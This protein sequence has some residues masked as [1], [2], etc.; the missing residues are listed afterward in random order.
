MSEGVQLCLICCFSLL[1]V[2]LDSVLV[3]WSLLQHSLSCQSTLVQP[4]SA[5]AHTGEGNGDG[6]GARRRRWPRPAAALL[7]QQDRAGPSLHRSG[8][9]PSSALALF[10]PLDGVQ[11]GMAAHAFYDVANMQ[12]V[13]FFNKSTSEH[14]N[15]L[16]ALRYAKGRAKKLLCCRN[17]CVMAVHLLLI[18]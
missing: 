12:H 6:V 7:A 18:S 8:P 4:Q 17:V 1:R 16:K 9:P 5:P 14:I 13:L 11:G 15:Y 2:F 10:C 3:P